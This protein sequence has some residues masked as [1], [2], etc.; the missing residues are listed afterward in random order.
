MIYKGDG[1]DGE[2]LFEA[3]TRAI[4]KLLD[5]TVKKFVDIYFKYDSEHIFYDNDNL[6]ENLIK[7]FGEVF[8]KRLR[9]KIVNI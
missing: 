4:G 6:D 3:R 9:N 7:E 1:L 8:A 5:N 2:R